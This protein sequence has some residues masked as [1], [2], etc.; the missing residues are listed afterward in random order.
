MSRGLTPALVLLALAGCGWYGRP[1]AS[2]A[3]VLDV[4]QAPAGALAT[5]PTLGPDDAERI[6]AARP[7]YAKEELLRRH[8]LSQR[9]YDAVR[10]HLVVGP[11]AAPG[12]L[13]W[14]PP[15]P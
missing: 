14:V 8:I 2:V 3:T 7:Y 9:Q 15:E 6:V 1:P 4:N 12:Y 11:P 10:D 13:Q 5:L